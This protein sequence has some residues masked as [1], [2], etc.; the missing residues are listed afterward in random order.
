[1]AGDSATPL[2]RNDGLPFG[3]ASGP[4]FRPWFSSSGFVSAE[5]LRWLGRPNMALH[6]SAPR[7]LDWGAATVGAAGERQAVRPAEL[8]K[9]IGGNDAK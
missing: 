8:A 9:S 7:R 1:M 3:N 4:V 2:S 6:P 5:P